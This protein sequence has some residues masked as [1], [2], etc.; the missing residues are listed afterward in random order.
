M[1][2][3]G[4]ETLRAAWFAMNKGLPLIILKGSGGYADV[5]SNLISSCKGKRRIKERINNKIVTV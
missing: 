3:G 2:G 5:I 4:L 1:V